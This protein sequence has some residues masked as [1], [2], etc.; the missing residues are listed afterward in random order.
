MRPI[1]VCEVRTVDQPVGDVSRVSGLCGV[2]TADIGVLS[3]SDSRKA[4]A[5]RTSVSVE[6]AHHGS[7]RQEWFAT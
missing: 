5:L 6:H 3:F 4:V 1:I 2:A 7:R